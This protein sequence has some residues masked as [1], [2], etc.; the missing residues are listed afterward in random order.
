MYIISL[1]L[2]SLSLSIYIYI[3][4]QEAGPGRD[5][6]DGGELGVEQKHAC[7]IHK[8]YIQVTNNM[9]KKVTN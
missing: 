9:F 2:S 1:S 7:K 3:Y 4:P 5:P 6:T 8:Q